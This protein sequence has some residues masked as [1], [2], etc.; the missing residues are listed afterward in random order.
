MAAALIWALIVVLAG[1]FILLSMIYYNCKDKMTTKE[2]VTEREEADRR[3]RRHRRQN[4][5]IHY[6]QTDLAEMRRANQTVAWVP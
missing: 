1:L 6:D 2:T 3:R 5:S 4:G